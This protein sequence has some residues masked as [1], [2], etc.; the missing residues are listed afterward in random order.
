MF[1]HKEQLEY[2]LRPDDYL[3]PQIHRSEVERLFL[4]AWHPVAVASDLSR[5]GDFATLEIL[6]RPIQ[7]RRI[8][9]VL[10]AYLNV[11]SHRHCLL[12]DLARGNAP[13]IVCQYHGW[14]YAA[15]GKV[16]KVPDGGC[17]KPFDRE[18]ARLQ[19]FAVETCGELVFVR[20]AADGPTLRDHLGEW[21]DRVAASFAAPYKCNW[22]YSSD[23]ACNWKIPVENTVET[24]HLPYIHPT[25]LGG[26]GLIPEEA[27]K[28]YLENRSTTLVYDLGRESEP[29]KKQ[30]QVVGW[31]GGGTTTDQYIH[32]HIFPNLVF[33]F[34]DLFTYAQVYLPTGPTTSSTL[35]W[36]FSLDGTKRNPFARVIARLAARHGVQANSAIQREDAS[37][38]AAQQRG[39]A[40]TPFKGCIGT[41]E[42]RI[43]C[44]HQYL[45]SACADPSLRA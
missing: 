25:T 7:L 13:R 43:W 45:R 14:E 23:F 28:H 42:E 6:G 39:L 36:M 24:Y 44:F 34:S 26:F 41:R 38:F 40:A 10:R 3:S 19:T 20:I 11:C 17:F 2:V 21:F 29:V 1:V 16:A 31:L 32:H 9:G 37:V 18:N 8:D 15:D 27:Q 4:A 35:A 12:T 30:R 22:R 5:E 33:T